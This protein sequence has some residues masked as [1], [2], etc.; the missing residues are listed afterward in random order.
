MVYI[1][2]SVNSKTLTTAP[3]TSEKLKNIT[4]FFSRVILPQI[5]FC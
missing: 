2:A 5:D 3:Q 4:A 1:N